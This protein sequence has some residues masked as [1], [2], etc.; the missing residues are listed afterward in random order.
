MENLMILPAVEPKRFSWLNA[1]ATDAEVIAETPQREKRNN[2]FIEANTK[3]VELSHL[4]NECIVPVFSKDNELTISHPAFIETV[5]DAVST[6]YNGETIETP[7]IR[8]SH[9]VKGRIPEAIHKPA[10]QLLESDKTIYYERMMFCIEI[11][12]IYETIDGNKLTLTV[13][14]VRAYNTMNLYSKKT[15]EKFKVFVGFR[16]RV[17]CN[18]CVSSDGYVGQLEVSNT[19]DLYRNVL[20]MLHNY[21]PAKHIHLMQM[22]G[23]TYMTEHQ[24]CQILGKMRLYQA[25]PQKIQRN[26]PQL[27]IT[28]T[29]I[30]SV[31]K[32]YISDPNFGSYGSDI[33]MWKFYNLLTGAN[34]SSYIDSFLDRSL[35]A[36]EMALGINSA[37]HGDDRYSWFIN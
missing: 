33:D 19:A 21:N 35:N 31:A 5:A 29:Q 26:I 36:T 32:A 16:N 17:C 1:Y 15:V 25:L 28:D 13:G 20:D 18:L 11:P 24:F 8:V 22:L 23:N 37:L 34:K 10:N 14:G 27:L 7:D 6:F 4:T 12:T 30:N 3:A 9:I 2:P